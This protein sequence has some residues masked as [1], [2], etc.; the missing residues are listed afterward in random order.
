MAGYA[1][2]VRNDEVY[3]NLFMN[4]KA[5]LRTEKGVLELVQ[6]SDYPWEGTIE[7]E[8]AGEKP[9]EAK[10]H[11]RIPGWALDQPVPSDLFAFTGTAEEEFS[12]QVNGETAEME[13]QDG[14]VTVE[15]EW[16]KG[17]RI[18]LELPMQ[19]RAIIA[20]DSV[21]EKKGLVAIQYGPLV[22]C[23]EQ[24]DNPVDVLEATNGRHPVFGASYEPG[25]LGG[26]HVLEG[27]GL[28]LVP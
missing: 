8:I 4:G 12:L 18:L 16:N 1:Y 6:C 25:L 7:M 5:E 17:D 3:V 20:H 28:V 15:R 21:A 22:Y 27:E 26:V 23:A 14:Y 11:I 24:T 2:A 10:I 13:V 9:L 19:S